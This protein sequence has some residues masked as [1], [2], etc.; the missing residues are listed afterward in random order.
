MKMKSRQLTVTSEV[1]KGLIKRVHEH[2]MLG[3]WFDETGRF[4]INIVKRKQKLPFMIGTV[5]GVGC[6]PNVGYLAVQV[7]LKLGEVVILPSFLYNAEA[8]AVYTPKEIEELEKVQGNMLRQFLEVPKSTPYYGLLMETGWLTMEARLDYK[9]LM[10]YHNIVH[11]DDKRVIKKI[12]EAQA[13]RNREGTWYNSV[14][15]IITKYNIELEVKETMKS[16][17]KREVKSKIR[18]RTEHTIKEKCATL[19][20]TRTVREDEFCLKEYL[21]VLPIHISKHVLRYRLHMIDV[22]KN[23]KNAWKHETCLLCQCEQGSTEHFF[24]CNR[25][26]HLRKA[27]DVTQLSEQSPSKMRDIAGYMKD[28]ETLV[29]PKSWRCKKKLGSD[30]GDVSK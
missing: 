17:W 15:K 8:F 12:I 3:T 20:K 11:S 21:K 27:W 22:P 16:K 13:R 28:V 4:E 1:K 5:K 24:T 30:S 18:G 10:L 7:R 14:Q 26:E 9:K 25:T 19:T 29:E 2:K 6:S 23:Y